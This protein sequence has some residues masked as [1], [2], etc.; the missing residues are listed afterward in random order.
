MSRTAVGRDPFVAAQ[1][2]DDHVRDAV[3]RLKQPN[4]P[5]SS[6]TAAK[7]DVRHFVYTSFDV[8]KD[9]IRIRDGGRRRRS[10]WGG[11]LF[12]SRIIMFVELESCASVL[13]FTT[14][15]TS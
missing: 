1:H 9:E 14:S 5:I 15:L 8:E 2:P 11:A 7:L 13:M 10:V 3:L 6:F 12:M 4:T